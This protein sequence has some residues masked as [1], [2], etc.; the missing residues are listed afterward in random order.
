MKLTATIITL[1][2]ALAFMGTA[3]A[4]MPGKTVEYGGGA[5]GQVVF[6]GKSHADAGLSCAACHPDLFS[7]KVEAKMTMAD[8]N[9]GTYCFSCHQAGG[10]AFPSTDC[11]KCHQK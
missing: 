2:A 4:S 1:V 9:A 5:L 8:H 10:S 11:A 3:I 7:M 6:D